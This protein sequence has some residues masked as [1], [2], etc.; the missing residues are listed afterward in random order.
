MTETLAGTA[1]PKL[2]LIDQRLKALG[3]SPLRQKMSDGKMQYW[4][5]YPDGRIRAWRDLWGCKHDLTRK[6]KPMN[7]EVITDPISARRASQISGYSMSV[8]FRY[9]KD[10][11]I[12]A[13]TRKKPWMI[14]KASV[15]TWVEAHRK[16][17]GIHLPRKRRPTQ[18]APVKR[19]GWIATESI[20]GVWELRNGSS[21]R[22]ALVL[23]DDR[24]LPKRIAALLQLTAGL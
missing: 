1:T 3:A 22:K 9:I 11:T 17:G 20:K 6:D 2:R 23:S 7:T 18:T 4:T 10:G 5:Q 13:D 16:T 12:K 8:I 15:L 19:S 21:D 24:G 14:S